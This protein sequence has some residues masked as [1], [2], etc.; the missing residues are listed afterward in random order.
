MRLTG[1]PMLAVARGVSYAGA[2]LK[3]SESNEYSY[4]VSSAE[5]P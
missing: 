5:S 2:V 1:L 3:C 4:E